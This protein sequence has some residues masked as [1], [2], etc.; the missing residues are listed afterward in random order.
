VIVGRQFLKGV[1]LPVAM[2]LGKAGV[3]ARLSRWVSLTG[4]EIESDASRILVNSI[5]G[6]GFS[7]SGADK[8]LVNR[9]K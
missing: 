9:D 1:E 8:T 3:S 4:H 5:C 2:P 6:N 7:S